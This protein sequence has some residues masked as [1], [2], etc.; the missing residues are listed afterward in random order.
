MCGLVWPGLAWFQHV[1]R[2][3]NVNMT[4]LCDIITTNDPVYGQLSPGV[5]LQRPHDKFLTAALLQYSAFTRIYSQGL[6]RIEY[7]K[8]FYK[9]SLSSLGGSS[10][11]FPSP[12]C[13]QISAPAPSVSQI[14]HCRFQMARNPQNS[15]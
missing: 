10:S 15:Y 5:P 14:S 11:Q 7:R 4:E 12:V 8:Q 9:F 1:Y 2:I 3:V 13:Q 6:F